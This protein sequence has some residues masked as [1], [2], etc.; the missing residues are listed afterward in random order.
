[1]LNPS[2]T[3]NQEASSTSECTVSQYTTPAV[4]PDA[5]TT[6]ETSTTSH[7]VTMV[8]SANTSDA[9]V[10]SNNAAATSTARPHDQ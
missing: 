9:S 10:R 7:V 1:M 6:G 3:S 8:A 5:R 4:S 2:A